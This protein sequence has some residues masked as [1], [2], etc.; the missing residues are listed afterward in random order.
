M[1]TGVPVMSTGVPR[2]SQIMLSTVLNLT[3]S[4][5]T[6]FKWQWPPRK[7]ESDFIL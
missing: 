2:L 7:S 4:D 3:V 6:V 5:L 1:S